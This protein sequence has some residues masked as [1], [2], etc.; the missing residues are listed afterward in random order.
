MRRRGLVRHCTAVAALVTGVLT[1]SS[2]ARAQTCAVPGTHPTI[3][4]AVD[5]PTCTTIDLAAQS[6]PESIEIRRSLTLGGPAAGGAVI[7]GL[8]L[9]VGS[10]TA[11]NLEHLEVANGCSPDALRTAGGATV[12]GAG[13]SVQRSAVLPCPELASSIFSDGFET[14]DTGRWSS[15]TP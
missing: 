7:E 8:V 13:I 1:A 12:V 6:Y 14:G 9:V 5:D 15:T 10:G 4:E 2:P 3:Q 11:V